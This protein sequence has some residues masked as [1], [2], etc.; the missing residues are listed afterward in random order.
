MLLVYIKGYGMGFLDFFKG[1]DSTQLNK[2]S[3]LHNQLITEFSNL[4][5]KELVIS[6]CIA[7]LLARVAYV[8]FKLDSEEVKQIQN[9]LKSWNL[10]DSIN[11]DNLAQMAI[12]HI[13]E[14]AGLENHLYVHPLNDHLSKDEKY[15]V[16]QSLFLLAASDGEVEAIECE[17]I[18]LIT[19]GLELSNQHFIS[20]RAEVIEFLKALK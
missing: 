1:E 8:D 2:Y 7:G 15:K 14:M 11:T 10:N 20:A 17:E 3:K 12:N 19:K 6:S 18:R 13:Q 9:S 16:L 5:E 4:S